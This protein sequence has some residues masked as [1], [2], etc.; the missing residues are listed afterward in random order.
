[1]FAQKKVRFLGGLFLSAVFDL[2]GCF[3][4]ASPRIPRN[5]GRK[6]GRR[7]GGAGGAMEGEEKGRRRGGRGRKENQALTAGLLFESRGA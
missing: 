1:M 6:E 7:Q 5:Q 4:S 2:S 3:S